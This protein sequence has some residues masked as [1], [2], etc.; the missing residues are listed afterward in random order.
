MKK[1]LSIL[2]F[3]LSI[4]SAY[5]QLVD[6]VIVKMT[7]INDNV[8]IIED[9]QLSLKLYDNPAKLTI[10]LKKISKGGSSIPSVYQV[11]SV[12]NKITFTNSNWRQN[13]GDYTNGYK[14]IGGNS[15]AYNISYTKGA[16]IVDVT[17]NG[18]SVGA[19]ST[20]QNAGN[21][22]EQILKSAEQ[23]DLITIYKK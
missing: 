23:K 4:S 3:T 7:Y 12:N 15:Y 20:Q 17:K 11:A 10:E 1:I 18:V 6:Q 21:N 19:F 2:I 16:T 14:W 5:A 13:N 8:T 22:I 9:A